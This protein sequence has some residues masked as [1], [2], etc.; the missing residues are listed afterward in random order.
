MHSLESS[1]P[2]GHMF[3]QDGFRG[4]NRARN[5]SVHFKGLALRASGSLTK[6]AG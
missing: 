3:C 6:V 5:M 4:R 2:H 1:I